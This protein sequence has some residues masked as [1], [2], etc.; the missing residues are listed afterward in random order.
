MNP[1]L[2]TVIFFVVHQRTDDLNIDLLYDVHPVFVGIEDHSDGRRP[3]CG[4]LTEINLLG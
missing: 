3:I 1:N 4:E 2:V